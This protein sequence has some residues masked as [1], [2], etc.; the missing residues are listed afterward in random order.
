MEDKKQE[1]KAYTKPEVKKLGDVQDLTQG[2][3]N[4]SFDGMFGGTEGFLSESGV[5][6]NEIFS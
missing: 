3:G 4:G 5:G 6:N 2:S 1:R